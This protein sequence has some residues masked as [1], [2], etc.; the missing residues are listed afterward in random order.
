MYDVFYS[1]INT[2]MKYTFSNNIFRGLLFFFV[3]NYL[4]SDDRLF[5][6]QADMLESKRLED[7]NVKVISGNVIFT[8]G[9][10]T[11]KC[12]QGQHIENLGIVIL[13]DE[14]S[15]T[16]EELS[17]VADTLKFYSIE[18]QLLGI[19]NS[20]AWTSKYDL[21]ADSITIFTTQDSGIASG[22]VTLI[23]N[24]QILTAEKIIYKNY[25]NLGEI[26][27]TAFGNVIIKDSVVTATSGIARYSGIDRNTYL[28]KNPKIFDKDRV[29]NGDEIKLEYYE[30]KLR[31]IYIPSNAIATTQKKGFVKINSDSSKYPSSRIE[32]HPA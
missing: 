4:F 19:G 16:K 18:N 8:K 15:S 29:L 32:Y 24:G 30:N 21:K 23:Q 5:L 22:N 20:H 7:K 13:Y 6:K 27:Y 3:L 12:Q 28:T 2:L 31:T 26:S 17:F 9:N 11:L 1:N 10:L 25:P 14:V